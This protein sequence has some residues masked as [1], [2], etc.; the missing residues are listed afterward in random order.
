MNGLFH[1]LRIEWL[2]VKNY[3]SFWILTGIIAVCIPAFNYVV[4][5]VTNNTFPKVNGQ[6][7]LGSPFSFPNVWKTVPFN[8]GLMLFIPAI[9]IITLLTNEFT[10]KT[11]RQNI[12]DGWSRGRFIS[13]K[14]I[15]TVLLSLFVTVV[16]L[17]TCLYFG[18]YTEKTATA[19]PAWPQFR[20]IVF[21]FIEMLSYSMIAVIIAMSIRRAGLAMGIFFLYM[22]VEQFVVVLG[23]NKYKVDWINYLPEEVTDNLIPQPFKPRMIAS[24]HTAIWEHHLPGYITV[25]LIYLILYILYVSWRFRRNDL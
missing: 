19:S 13:V 25:S 9:L 18:F 24:D 7:I 4:Y 15:E 22:I 5:D 23:R 12:I 16:V 1:T 14:I 10:Y 20:F 6:N 3:R 21:F 2:K 8:A 11:H 17:F